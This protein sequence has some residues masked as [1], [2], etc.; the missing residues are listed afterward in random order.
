MGTRWLAI[1]VLILTVT[2]PVLARD[3]PVIRAVE[4]PSGIVP[5]GVLTLQ[6]ENFVTGDDQVLH[7]LIT[8]QR[9]FRIT[10]PAVGNNERV[11]LR[12]PEEVSAG[13]VSILLMR[14]SR[15]GEVEEA[16]PVEY[17]VLS[18]P[19]IHGVSP[20]QGTT[21]SAAL[22][23]GRE[24]GKDQGSSYVLFVG[25]MHNQFRGSARALVTSWTDEA[26]SIVVPLEMAAGPCEIRV[27]K[28]DP[29]TNRGLLLGTRGDSPRFLVLPSR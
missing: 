5:G 17:F 16:A 25:E 27:V 2:Q 13:P 18:P 23:R 12:I 24:L 7:A 3:A 22:I 15:E 21:G 8:D 4:P 19:E 6:G 11:Q 14:R 10:T 29:E 20:I 1:S 28:M 9:N 26:I